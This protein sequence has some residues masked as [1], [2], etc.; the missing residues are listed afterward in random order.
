MTKLEFSTP[1]IYQRT[2]TFF[3][4]VLN[5]SE[6]LYSHSV[7]EATLVPRSL[8]CWKALALNPPNNWVLALK[9]AALALANGALF[10]AKGWRVK[11]WVIVVAGAL[12]LLLA[13]KVMRRF[14]YH[15]KSIEEIGTNSPVVPDGVQIKRAEG[16]TNTLNFATVT[17]G[18][19]ERLVPVQ[20]LSQKEKWVIC[21]DS[22]YEVLFKMIK[23]GGGRDNRFMNRILKNN[24]L[25]D[26]KRFLEYLAKPDSTGAYPINQL[27]Q[28]NIEFV[29]I[30]ELAEQHKVKFNVRAIC[31]ETNKSL[32][33]EW[34]PYESCFKMV[35]AHDDKYYDLVERGVHLI[36]LALLAYPMMDH[37]N[38]LRDVMEKNN[39]PFNAADTLALKVYKKDSDIKQEEY[40]NLTQ[41]QKRIVWR[42]ADLHN[43]SALT[44]FGPEPQ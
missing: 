26:E 21:I 22:P 27:G 29:K 1:L 36:T 9:V 16:V 44:I 25:L 5:F 30:M 34:A 7:W 23:H 20:W 19:Q 31:P 32:L 10:L 13:M 41:E 4:K 14:I 40:A 33:S 2:T 42:V 6:R 38:S 39:I 18:G 17:I 11:M 8:D 15:F 28:Y 3:N 12:D 43:R 24:D 37:L 35:A